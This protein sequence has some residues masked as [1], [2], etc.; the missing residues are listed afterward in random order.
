MYF[1]AFTHP[2]LFFCQKYTKQNLK[3]HCRSV[4]FFPLHMQDREEGKK[5]KKKKNNHKSKTVSLTASLLKMKI[6]KTS[7]NVEQD[8]SRRSN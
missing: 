4:E 7:E 5:E 3:I 1:V 2:D 8:L 6:E